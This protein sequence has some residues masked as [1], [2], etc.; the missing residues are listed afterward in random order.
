MQ[1]ATL[2]TLTASCSWLSKVPLGWTAALLKGN[3]LMNGDIL[4]VGSLEITQFTRGN[5]KIKRVRK[6]KA[7]TVLI[8][9]FIM[10]ESFGSTYSS[11]TDY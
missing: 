3:T 6:T 8:S 5:V 1:E 11:N 4:K 9:V 7:I 10:L 2:I